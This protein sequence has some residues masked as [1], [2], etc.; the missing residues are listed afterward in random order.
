MAEQDDRIQIPVEELNK[1]RDEWSL[2]VGR[3]LTAFAACEYHTYLYIRTFG[4]PATR[5]V[6]MSKGLSARS[7]IAR[8]AVRRI[9]VVTPIEN[10]VDVAFGQLKALAKSRN[11]AAHNPP[12]LLP[13]K[14]TKTNIITLRHE[15]R[16]ARNPH[17][18]LTLAQLKVL[19]EE[20]RALEDEF[21]LLYGEVQQPQNRRGR[22]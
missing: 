14:D 18:D 2:A 19:E 17:R 3:F 22:P 7:D 13:F 4:E 6:A 8:A 20:A 15:L 9:G 10:R 11:L 1:L 21:N 12:M 16:D 5:N